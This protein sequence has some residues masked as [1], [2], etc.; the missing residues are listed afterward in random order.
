[1]MILAALIFLGRETFCISK[2]LAETTSANHVFLGS[3]KVAMLL[4]FACEAVAFVASCI[5]LAMVCITLNSVC[6]NWRDHRRAG[7]F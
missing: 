4:G 7:K 6:S 5:G 2:T 1:M 3:N